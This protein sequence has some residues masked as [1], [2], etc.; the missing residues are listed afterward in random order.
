M[1]NSLEQAC[2]TFFIKLFRADPRLKG[3]EIVHFEEE[4]K[5]KNFAIIVEAKQGNHNLAAKGGYDVEVTVELR[6]PIG[7]K[8]A[9]TEIVSAALHEI[10]YENADPRALN[11]M[12][13]EAGLSD[14]LI[15]DES[16]SDRQNSTDLRK[17]MLSFP[18]QAKLA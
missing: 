6:T 12:A 3:K 13:V 5:A 18:L 1:K 8:K 11:L 14:L 2:E 15:K 10:V 7:A 4:R 9:N 16:T 17:R